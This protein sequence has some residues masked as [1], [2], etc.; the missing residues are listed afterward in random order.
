MNCKNNHI[1]NKTVSGTKFLLK[2]SALYA[3]KTLKSKKYIWLNL[4]MSNIYIDPIFIL[5]NSPTKRVFHVTYKVFTIH[6]LTVTLVRFR[7]TFWYSDVLSQTE[8]FH[9]FEKKYLSYYWVSW[10]MNS[11]FILF[12]TEYSFHEF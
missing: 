2:F 6:D 1:S 4:Q 11:S 3:L 8:Q 7:M 9:W 5:K 12:I 10:Q